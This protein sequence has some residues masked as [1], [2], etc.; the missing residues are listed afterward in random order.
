MRPRAERE[1]VLELVEQGL[2]DTEVGRVLAIPRRTIG[3]WRRMGRNFRG[4]PTCAVC[5]G[6][7]AE[8]PSKP[9]AYILGMYLGD[10]Y[11]A[12]S[13]R[14]YRLTFAC[15]AAY[16]RIIERCGQALGDLMP[17]KVA[18]SRKRPESRCIDIWM[19]SNHWPCFFPQHGTGRKHERP[20]V[21]ADWQREIIEVQTAEFLTGL[22]HSD[23]C[24]VETLDRGVP[25]VRY[26][27]SNKSSDIRELFCDA[28]ERVGVHWT[29]NKPNSIAIYR[30]R[31]TA[32]L[33]T[34]IERK[35]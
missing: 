6:E 10:G 30:K 22:I 32:F 4:K 9:Y 12:R 25:S 19:Y 26:H 3:D 27:F 18:G 20:I 23:G 29:R 15:D 14:T 35:R 16:P 33:D 17:G 8:L 5:R 13:T 34:M 11:I 28:L 2:T 7:P 31:D 1:A 21:L 24:R